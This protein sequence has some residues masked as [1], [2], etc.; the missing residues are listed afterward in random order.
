MDHSMLSWPKCYSTGFYKNG[1]DKYVTSNSFAKSAIIPSNF[2][3]LKNTKT[4]LSFIPNALLVVNLCKFTKS[5]ALSL[6]SRTC[7][8]KIEYLLTFLNQ[9]PLF[10]RNLNISV[11][12]SFSS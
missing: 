8:T 12:P 6:S 4:F 11:F 1:L 9:S 10:L 3:I 7:R 5:I 2:P